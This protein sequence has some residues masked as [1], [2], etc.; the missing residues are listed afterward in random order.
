MTRLSRWLGKLDELDKKLG[1]PPLEYRWERK[2]GASRFQRWQM[3]RPVLAPITM[4][5]AALVTIIAVDGVFFL[6][7]GQE[8]VVRWPV[9]LPIA[10]LAAVLLPLQCRT[11]RDMGRRYEAWRHDQDLGAHT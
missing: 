2:G 10:A 3:R 1:A 8:A 9:V 5:A 11:L 4:F 7:G 6:F